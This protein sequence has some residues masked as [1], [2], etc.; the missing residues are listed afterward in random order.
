VGNALDLPLADRSV[1]LT[2]SGLVLNFI[3]DSR[4]ALAEMERVTTDGGTVA[5]YV[6]DYAGKMEFLQTFWEAATEFKQES[7]T[8]DEAKRFSSCTTEALANLFAGAG[9]HQVTSAAIEI[10]THFADFDDYWNPFLGGQG[11]APGYVKSLSD[12]DRERLRRLIHDRLPVQHDGSIPLSA[13]AL[14]V[15]GHVGSR[16]PHKPMA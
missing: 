6:W 3:P 15:Q 1:D 7:A 11:P 12:M 5:I 8:L 14:A 4:S 13:R 16:R 9:L 10:E 2:L